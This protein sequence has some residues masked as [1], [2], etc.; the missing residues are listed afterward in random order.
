ML[1]C[2][3]YLIGCFGMKWKSSPA[4]CLSL[5]RAYGVNRAPN[6][7]TPTGRHSQGKFQ[8]ALRGAMSEKDISRRPCATF[9]AYAVWLRNF[10]GNSCLCF[11]HH[12]LVYVNVL[13]G[14]EGRER[15]KQSRIASGSVT[16][17]KHC[18]GLT[19]INIEMN[20]TSANGQT[21]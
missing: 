17:D 13:Q 1:S 15:V 21:S 9:P 2:S 8:S 14:C 20:V 5:T 11:A 10:R 18:A 7:F 12:R 3:P 6:C 16:K 4:R 19:S